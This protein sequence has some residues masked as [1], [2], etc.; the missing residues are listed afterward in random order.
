MFKY[1][2]FLIKQKIITCAKI[3]RSVKYYY[4]IKLFPKNSHTLAVYIIFFFE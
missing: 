3:F 1:K 4:C 2:S